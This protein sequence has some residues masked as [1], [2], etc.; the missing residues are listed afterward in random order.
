[1][2]LDCFRRQSV[3]EQLDLLRAE[4]VYI[5]KRTASGYVTV[6]YQLDY[7]YVEI[8]YTEYRKSIYKLDCFSEVEPLDPYLVGVDIEALLKMINTH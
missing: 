5:G 3:P 2:L 6:M 1:M 4:G 8:F 7:F